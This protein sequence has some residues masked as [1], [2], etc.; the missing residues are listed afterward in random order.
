MK[1]KEEIAKDID[2]DDITC[3]LN[4]VQAQDLTQILLMTPSERRLKVSL[5]FSN[6][7]LTDLSRKSGLNESGINGTI[8]RWFQGMNKMPLG[9]A[10]RLSRVFGVPTEILFESIRYT[11]TL[12]KAVGF[13]ASLD[14]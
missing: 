4:P 11:G 7:T 13:P 12:P 5:A 14:E 10:F 3:I 9:V 8:S 6:I 2:F 1:D